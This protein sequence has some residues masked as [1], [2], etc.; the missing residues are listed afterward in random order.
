MRRGQQSSR[1]DRPVKIMHR[2][3]QPSS[4][5]RPS[6]SIVFL[7]AFH[8]DPTYRSVEVPSRRNIKD[9]TPHSKVDGLIVQAIVFDQR[10]GGI[11][12][13]DG[14]WWA[15][16]EDDWCLGPEVPVD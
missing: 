1:K 5:S 15:A 3:R 9:T 7:I 13:E 14:W 11:G 16:R 2:Q 4:K 8:G 12:L 10:F 6:P